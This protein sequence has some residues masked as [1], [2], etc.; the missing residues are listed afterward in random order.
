MV[1]EF[2][3]R[4]KDNPEY[5]L[6]E[7][8]KKIKYTEVDFSYSMS[9]SVTFFPKKYKVVAE[10]VENI[11]YN[12]LHAHVIEPVCEMRDIVVAR[13]VLF[14]RLKEKLG[15]Y[16]GGYMMPKKPSDLSFMNEVSPVKPEYHALVKFSLGIQ[17]GLA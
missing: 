12:A 14:Q 11:I 4:L 3:K 6:P 1:R 5:V 15:S 16:T 10:V 13:P 9:E 8:Y 17:L 7:G 2:N